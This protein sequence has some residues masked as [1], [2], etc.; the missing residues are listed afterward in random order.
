MIVAG[1]ERRRTQM[2]H[3][4]V[5]RELLVERRAELLPQ[6]A[7]PR[8]VREP[9]HRATVAEGNRDVLRPRCDLELALYVEDRALSGTTYIGVPP[10]RE[11]SA[12]HD[13]R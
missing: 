9:I 8:P 7:G 6:V 3:G 1:V 5:A 2:D 4:L 13:A 10:T 12:E 11:S